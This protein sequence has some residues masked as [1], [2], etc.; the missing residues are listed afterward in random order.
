MIQP[1]DFLA[2]AERLLAG[3]LEV[4]RR[5]AVSRAYYAAYHLAKTLITER[6]GVVL[7]KTADSHQTVQRCLINSQHAQLRAAGSR[8]ESLRA[9]PNCA[10]YNL[11][12]PRFAIPEAATFD[13]EMAKGIF[14][15]IAAAELNTQ[16]FQEVVRIYASGVL[17]LQLKSLPAS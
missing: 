11:T 2:Q 9:E 10:D 17:K 13:V 1:R 15:A 16:S 3:G 4:D 7:S 8:L 14:A 6:C 12:D 5:S